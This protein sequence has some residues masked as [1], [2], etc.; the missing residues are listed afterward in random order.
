[1][2][3]RKSIWLLFDPEIRKLLG[4]NEQ[5]LKDELDKT[6]DLLNGAIGAMETTDKRYRQVVEENTRLCEHYK[7]LDK[8]FVC[9]SNLTFWQRLL[10]LFTGKIGDMK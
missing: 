5:K 4:I 7:T 10:F 8:F 3:K 2:H 9:I 1:M 6:Y